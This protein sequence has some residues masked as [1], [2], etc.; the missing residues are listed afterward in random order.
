MSTG[1]SRSKS[2]L[3][4]PNYFQEPPLLNEDNNVYIKSLKKGNNN[5]LVAIRTRPVNKKEMKWSKEKGLAERCIKVL[6]EKIVMIKDISGYKPE[7]AFRGYREKE[8]TY[9]FDYAFN[10]D[11]DQHYIFEKTTKFLIEGVMTG[12]NAT[13]FAYGATGAGKT[14]TMMGEELND[15][16]MLLS[17]QE[18]F[19]QIDNVTQDKDYQL[20]ITYI[21][22]YNEIIKDLLNSK[23]K[24]C[25]LRED[26]TRGITIAGVTEIMTTNTE[27]IM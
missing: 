5:I 19:D 17:I 3:K 6:D 16:V 7:E 20:K 8:K 13:V 22:V 2:T 23:N 26:P 10:Q 15:G 4:D 1:E 18:L 11:I 9:A 24:N 14:Y 12:F 21:E 27:E 25:D